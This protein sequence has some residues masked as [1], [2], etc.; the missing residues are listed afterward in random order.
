MMKTGRI[1]TNTLA[2]R[3]VIYALSVLVFVG[4][5]F[6]TSNNANSSY[7]TQ[8]AN[9]QAATSEIH[10]IISSLHMIDAHVGW[11][12]SWYTTGESV[13]NDILRTTDGG[14]HWR[15]MF[16]CSPVSSD[17]GKTAGFVTCNSDFRSAMIAS[18]LEPQANNQ[19]RIYHTSD[20]GQTWLGSSIDARSF[21]QTS[22]VFVDGLHGWFFGTDTFP[23]RDPGSSY[24]GQNIVLFR[25][26]DG[27]KTWDKI[28]RGPAISQLPGTS[29][30]AYGTQ[31][32][33]T[34]NA[35]LTFLNTRT[36]WLIGTTYQKDTTN[37]PW[38]YVTHDAG[39]TWQKVAL[40]FPAQ[41]SVLW[42][43]QFFDANNGL[44]PIM[45]SGPA[46]AYVNRTSIYTTHD[47]GKTW[48][49]T[50]FVPFDVTN[51]IFR[52]MQNATADAPDGNKVFY[53]TS[54]GWQHWT[55]H[56]ATTHFA[57]LYSFTFVSPTVGWA[58]G[59]TRGMGLPEPGGGRRA[60][61]LM[62][63]QHTTDGGRTWHEIA[64]SKV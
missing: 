12:Q 64:H 25:T 13:H 21:N 7:T 36:G 42:T 37:T 24:I 15:V 18:V 4:C 57:Q 47:A 22:P 48:T 9:K 41:A 11:T 60:G 54:D 50:A 29:D 5:G 23:G 62:S 40:T 33:F 6:S 32:P 31:P 2:I 55:K 46:P 1:R 53:T 52:T 14:V 38:L 34:A 10:G 35:R 44:L 45:V 19:T 51:A 59:E 63:I 3:P 20:G 58:I 56:T 26:S 28:A 17:G 43:P 16:T 8:A 61:D 30:D 49:Q 27:G 39:N